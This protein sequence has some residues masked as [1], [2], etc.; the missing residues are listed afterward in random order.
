MIPPVR[1]VHAYLPARSV[2]IT[3]GCAG[4]RSLPGDAEQQTQGA[5]LDSDAEGY[6]WLNTGV[7]IAQGMF[8]PQNPPSRM[9]IYLCSDDLM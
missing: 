5:L 9:D 7:C 6:S 1:A 2:R 3:S 4:G 8:D